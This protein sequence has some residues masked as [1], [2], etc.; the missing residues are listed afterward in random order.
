M[1]ALRT[2]IFFIGWALGTLAM[3]AL[4][5]PL[6][7]MPQR[8]TWMF[9]ITWATLTLWWLRV[10]CGLHSQIVSAP[11]SQLIACKHQSAWDT[12]AL[13]RMFGNPVFVLKRELYL[14]PIFGWFLWKS[15][16]IA[17]DRRDGRSAYDQIEK[18]A[19]K[20]LAQGRRIIMFPEGTRVRVGD[21]KPYRSGIG[22][23]SA[24]LNLPVTLAAVNAGLYWPKH[25]LIKQ[26]GTATL[27]FLPSVPV[28]DRDIVKWMAQV[29]TIIEKES[30]ELAASAEKL[31]IA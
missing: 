25:S 18:Q 28:C 30:A 8:F 31:P 16:Q 3:G 14:V 2:A 10:T 22:R 19:P 24:L 23:V 27:K 15:G 29:E 9:N 13:Q 21:K 20:M 7:L 11:D 17:I 1:Q 6:L 4:G 26:P 12:I 5:L